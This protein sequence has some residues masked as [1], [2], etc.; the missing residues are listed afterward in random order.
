MAEALSDESYLHLARCPQP[1]LFVVYR[2]Y[3]PWRS[4]N[5]AF[6]FVHQVKIPGDQRF[7]FT[8][9]FANIS[10]EPI[11]GGLEGG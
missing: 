7:Q 9:I 11:D 8:A 3:T 1:S 2:W 10:E 4:R 6:R 5:L